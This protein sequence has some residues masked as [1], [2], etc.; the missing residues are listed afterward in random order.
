MRSSAILLATLAA[1]FASIAQPCAAFAPS[2]S[3]M[4][5]HRSLQSGCRQKLRAP[6][7][8]LDLSTTLAL[9]QTVN[10]VA[11]APHAAYSWYL[12][13]LDTN[14]MVVDSATAS[15]LYGLGK[16]TSAAISKKK[17]PDMAK[18]IARWSALGVADGVCTH[19]WYGLLQGVA[20]GVE[21]DKGAEALAM[22]VASSTL[23]T[24][25]Y[26]AGFLVLLSLLEGKG[27]NGAMLRAKTDGEELFWKTTKVW[28]PTNALLFGL[29]PLHLRTIVSMGIHYVF[30]VGLALW[31]AS[32]RDSRAT[33]TAS[34]PESADY[35]NVG[36]AQ[37]RLATAFRA[38]D[39]DL[40][41]GGDAADL[42]APD[43]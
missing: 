42:P 13:A 23:Y 19:W 14:A 30:L 1:F 10:D 7:M 6:S 43:A 22:T 21:M 38:V 20:D 31:D 5:A 32:L 33:M 26:C 3:R 15:F 36:D 39:S 37:L 9:A 8:V 12:G 40:S 11:A 29:V 17:E 34:G 2:L 16:I 25:V 28:G 4:P 35:A 18:F 41:L 24:P 27:W